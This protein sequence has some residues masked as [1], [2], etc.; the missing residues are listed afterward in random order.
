MK[1]TRYSIHCPA[2]GGDVP[3]SVLPW[4]AKA[5]QCP[6]CAEF[7]TYE[8]NHWAAAWIGGFLLGLVIA[9]F[10]GVPWYILFPAAAAA[11]PVFFCLLI[12]IVGLIRPP[13][14]ILLKDKKYDGYFS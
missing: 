14:V 1:T 8:S 5:F 2:C 9:F 6:A 3:T 4:G 7:L 11:T 13:R 10:L 12:F